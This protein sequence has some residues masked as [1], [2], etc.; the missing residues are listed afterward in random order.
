MAD[1]RKTREQLRQARAELEAAEAAQDEYETPEAR[2]Q[3]DLGRGEWLVRYMRE[4]QVLTA[5]LC[6]ALEQFAGRDGEGWLFEV[7]VL[8]D[9]GFRVGS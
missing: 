6:A 5:E 1:P 7:P 8:E 3:R 9:D 2:E 4:H